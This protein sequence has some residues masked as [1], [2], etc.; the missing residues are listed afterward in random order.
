[1]GDINKKTRVLNICSR[2]FMGV[3]CL[4]ID[5]WASFFFGFVATAPPQQI[6]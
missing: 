2:Q 5:F 1:M 4:K 6:V 3:C